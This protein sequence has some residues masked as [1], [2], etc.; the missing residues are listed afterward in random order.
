MMDESALALEYSSCDRK[1]TVGQQSFFLYFLEAYHVGETELF[2]QLAG[3]N[4]K[5]I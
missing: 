3:K 1:T 2:R 4:D 5:I